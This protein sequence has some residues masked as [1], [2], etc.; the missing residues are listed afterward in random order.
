M[1]NQPVVI[2]RSSV[3]PGGIPGGILHQTVKILTAQLDLFGFPLRDAF[4]LLYFQEDKSDSLPAIVT[5]VV[6]SGW[7]F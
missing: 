3:C 7:H 1:T 2:L 5:N 4:Y 6:L